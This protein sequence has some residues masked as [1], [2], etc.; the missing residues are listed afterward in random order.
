MLPEPVANDRTQLCVFLPPRRTEAPGEPHAAP[1][2]TP[3]H[4]LPAITPDLYLGSYHPSG[5]GLH[6]LPAPRNLEVLGIVGDSGI[7][8]MQIVARPGSAALRLI[9]RFYTLY[10]RLRG[11][12]IRRLK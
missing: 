12:R 6:P 3:A 8:E 11:P 4:T 1:P 7:V 10:E 9:A 5:P 2:M